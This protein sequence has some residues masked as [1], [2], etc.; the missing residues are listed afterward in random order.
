MDIQLYCP[1]CGSKLTP[2][3]FESLVPEINSYVHLGCTGRCLEDLCKANGLAPEGIK[4]GIIKYTYDAATI[5]DYIAHR[6]DEGRSLPWLQKEFNERQEAKHTAI[7]HIVKTLLQA[8]D[9]AYGMNEVEIENSLDDIMNLY[10]AAGA[11]K[12][13]VTGFM[14]AMTLTK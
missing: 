6:S 2:Y 5:N 13:Y 4:T 11:D 1:D 8:E 3:Y 12:A 14:D 9:F 7:Q 10:C